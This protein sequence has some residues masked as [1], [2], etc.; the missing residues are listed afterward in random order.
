MI[1]KIL[2]SLVVV[3][4]L[5]FGVVFF[6]IDSIV[7][8]GIEVVGSEVL[9]TNVTVAS[10]T[11]SPLS[12]KGTIRG[13]TIQNPEGFTSEN[14]MQLGEVTVALN[15]SSLTSDVI[16]IYEIS[17]IEPLITY[18]TK[19]TTD[20]MRALLAN[21][22]STA[23]D[24]APADP[25][26][27]AS[28]GIVIKEINLNG[29]QVNLVASIIEQSFTLT[30]INLTNIGTENQAATVSQALEV[31]LRAVSRALLNADRPG[32]SEL[33]ESVGGR[34]QESVENAQEAVGQ[35]IED[36]SSRLRNILN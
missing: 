30:D 16:E 36:A 31:V 5:A 14:I 33:R 23:Q 27:A 24:T 34:L 11:I 32:L 29:A 22:P 25:D 10:V 28:Q 21:L 20:N 17:V 4:V 26:S 7:K 3:V 19:I 13:L 9:G 18:E 2:V 12:G 6:Y 1:K 8:S 35:G 15:L